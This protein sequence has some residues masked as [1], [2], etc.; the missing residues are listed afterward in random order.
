MTNDLPTN[1]A[2]S[3]FNENT[4]VTAYKSNFIDFIKK[5]KSNNTY[6][7]VSG[8]TI[9]EDINRNLIKLNDNINKPDKSSNNKRQ[10]I[11][12]KEDSNELKKLKLD[13]EL[14]GLKFEQLKK[15]KE[16]K[17]EKIDKNKALSKSILDPNL[18]DNLFDKAKDKMHQGLGASL[19]FAGNKI[20]DSKAG[21]FV[22]N[23]WQQTKKD[24][25]LLAETD[26][27]KEI[28]KTAEQLEKK[29]YDVKIKEAEEKYKISDTE[30]NNF[31][32]TNNSTETN[33][34]TETNNEQISQL[35]KDNVQFLDLNKLQNENLSELDTTIMQDNDKLFL[36]NEKQINLLTNIDKTLKRNE[37][38]KSD[39]ELEIPKSEIPKL[40]PNRK[41]K[42]IKKSKEKDSGLGL[43]S[44][45][46]GGG[47]SSLLPRLV[48]PML[49][50]IGPMVS[51][52]ASLAGP[53]L[54]VAGAATA[55]Y[56]AT[57]FAVDKFQDL[58]KRDEVA[59]GDAAETT[60]KLLGD[61]GLK[62]EDISNATGWGDD[63]EF[64]AKQFKLSI[65]NQV[66]LD[67]LNKRLSEEN[68]T[69]LE[70]KKLKNEQQNLLKDKNEL[71]KKLNKIDPKLY[72]LKE[73][74]LKDSKK[75][76][77]I[78]AAR[79]NTIYD[80]N[81]K[82]EMADNSKASKLGKGSNAQ[83]LENS[84]FDSTDVTM[85]SNVGEMMQGTLGHMQEGKKGELL[86][87]EVLSA[88]SSMNLSDVKDSISLNALAQTFNSIQSFNDLLTNKDETLEKLGISLPE[89][90]K[91]ELF[92][93]EYKKRGLSIYNNMY[94]L[95]T[96][97]NDSKGGEGINAFKEK[98]GDDLA[99]QNVGFKQWLDMDW[100]N[101]DYDTFWKS[102]NEKINNLKA[103]SKGG[104]LPKNKNSISIV[105]EEGP[106]VL[107]KGRIIPLN[108]NKKKTFSV[109]TKETQGDP[110]RA[111][112][113]PKQE[114]GIQTDNINN[115]IEQLYNSNKQIDDSVA[116]S[117]TNIVNT[118][119]NI[120]SGSGQS[121]TKPTIIQIEPSF[122]RY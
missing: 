89:K 107:Y 102:N 72:D 120:L 5:L 21:Q 68:L 70:T 87:A 1:I 78:S 40:E 3:G 31:T 79:E 108:N 101:E 2:T 11:I 37:E 16:K 106:E 55:A 62:A 80:I 22:K 57:S 49:S 110:T 38:R 113:S 119:N 117:N 39:S 43:M 12:I 114:N 83:L 54:L 42:K 103:F 56:K 9:Q 14:L 13:K 50:A 46:G 69:E 81:K 121:Q 71:D 111:N 84:G 109:P 63:D 118:V 32:E 82:T 86:N 98:L 91:A 88:T 36:H 67:K 33:N 28:T 66:Q 6:R 34:F 97:F 53:I 20:K 19:K 23:D 41:D 18:I 8:L 74:T 17:Q 26:K 99:N 90:T 75:N 27:G 64:A 7:L 73:K 93:S 29:E 104:L 15:E 24:F 44:M 95:G 65:E 25:G 112:I 61:T 122:V 51:S 59:L 115:K 92:S 96:T 48:G 45:L 100:N 58:Q 60:K 77:L 76:K 10:E 30:T 105:G 116:S 52:V 47:L 4:N 94:K 35:I 85:G